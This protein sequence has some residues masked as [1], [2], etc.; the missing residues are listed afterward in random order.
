MPKYM[1]SFKCIGSNCEDSCCTGWNIGVDIE[2][3]NK[4]EKITENELENL[5]KR[6]I[7]PPSSSENGIKM[8]NICLNADASC[9]FLTQSKLCLI[10]LKK[11]EEYLPNICFTYPRIFNI[12]DGIIEKSLILSCPEAAR[13]VLLNNKGIEFVEIEESCETRNMFKRVIDKN[14]FQNICMPQKYFCEMRSFT[15]ETLQN[16][17]YELWERLIILGVFYYKVMKIYEAKRLDDIPDLIVLYTNKINSCSFKDSFSDIPSSDL[18]QMK[19]LMRIVSARASKGIATQRYSECLNE[20][21]RGINYNAD[22]DLKKM[23]GYYRYAYENYY[24]PFMKKHEYI[25]E[26]YLINNVFK[27][28]FPLSS[29]KTVFE[30]YIMLALHYSLIKMHLIGM[31]GFHKELN[32]ALVVKLI[33]SYTKEV[34]HNSEYLVQ[35]FN[36]LKQNSHN[37]M[38]YITIM[39][40]N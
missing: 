17:N 7:M 22:N 27:S 26:N 13:L 5:I 11:G 36:L 35:M 25:L 18:I 20:F 40:K 32:D 2:T 4:L 31:S 34:E 30:E 12:V 19:L 29:N 14:H 21:L 8:G 10:H 24:R 1:S 16:R 15:L 39:I 23:A 33:Q 6:K 3:F 37:T 9:P 28:L 38:G